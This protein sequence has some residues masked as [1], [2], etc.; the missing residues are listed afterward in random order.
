MKETPGRILEAMI[1]FAGK[2][3]TLILPAYTLSFASTRIFDLVRTKSDIGALPDQ[4]IAHPGLRR[5]PKP[6]NS[7]MV[8]GP[9]ADEFLSL[10]CSTAWGQDGAFGWMTRVDARI[11][12]LGVPWEEAC[13][14]YHH[15]EELERVPY[16]Y[17][18]RFTGRYFED[19]VQKG[20]CQEV[21][22]SR[23]ST[24]PPQWQH[25]TIY[26]RMVSARIVE[27]SGDPL[28]PLESAKARD[29]VKVTRQMLRENSYSYVVNVE[30]VQN[31]V[32]YGAAEE[33]ANLRPD[34]R[35]VG[36][37]DRLDERR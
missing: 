11:C 32:K 31:W 5:L 13:S 16:R 36:E 3:K 37:Q 4:A 18:K 8:C 1:D 29:I 7:Y 34:E 19:G 15:A 10:A 28:I 23:S 2:N 9:R 22:F 35:F 6:M 33:I 27:K 24:T 25:Q 30:Q 20:N 17:H 26:P 21:M 12:I 14:L